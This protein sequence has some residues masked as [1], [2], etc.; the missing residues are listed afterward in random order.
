[1]ARTKTVAL[2]MIGTTFSLD[3]LGREL[4]ERGA[5]DAL[6]LLFAQ[7][8]HDYFAAS[9]AGSYVPLRDALRSSLRRLFVSRDIPLTDDEID[10]VLATLSELDP[11]PGA[12]DAL[13]ALGDAGVQV[14]ALTNGG[15]ALMEAL[16][17]RAGF[18]Q[19]VERI[20]SCDDLGTS[21]P[22]PSVYEA[23]R[24]VAEGEL[25]MVASHA[26]DIMGAVHAGL[27]GV[28]ISGFEKEY[29]AIFPPPDAVAPD[30]EAAAQAVIGFD[31]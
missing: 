3:R 30:L 8:L 26:W 13:R 28:W 10:G 21:K 23:A 11:N 16:L 20:V 4:T 7:T 24:E 15:T 17:E 18:S 5:S 9:Y 27:R 31:S 1:M 29:P 25:W 19:M 2:D 6:P 14:I 22:H 12:G